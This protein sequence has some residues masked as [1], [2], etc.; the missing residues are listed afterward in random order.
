MVALGSPHFSIYEFAEFL[1]LAERFP[2]SPEVETV[3]CTHR[4]VHAVLTERGWLERLERLG[5]QVVVDTCVVV[6]PL[7]RSSEGT[8][9]TNSGK[10]AYYTPPNTGLG[11]VFGSL[12]ECVRSAHLGR[13][14]RDPGL[15]E[16]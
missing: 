13:V 5:V 8:L 6:A 2:P 10:F 9:M 16:S 7:L 4:L 14:W 12:T 15:W 3:V 11:V 1:P